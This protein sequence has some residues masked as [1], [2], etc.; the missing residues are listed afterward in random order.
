MSRLRKQPETGSS[1][2]DPVT[3]DGDGARKGD[4]TPDE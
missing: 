1:G 2:P 4:E 3:P